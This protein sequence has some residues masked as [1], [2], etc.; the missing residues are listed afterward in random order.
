ME[1]CMSGRPQKL[2]LTWFN[3]DKALI[4]AEVGKYGYMWVD[5]K[6]PRY[7]ETHTLIADEVVSEVQGPKQDGT[8][9]SDL[10]D[11]EP[12]HDNLLIRGESG[13][14][15]EAITRRSEEHTSELQSR[16]D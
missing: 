7:C 1:K 14:V 4:P 10:A 6:D 9:Y 13:D 12:A 8:V 3:K 15:L 5:P 11:L 16:F 2:E